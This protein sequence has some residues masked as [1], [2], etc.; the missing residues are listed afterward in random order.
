LE[1]RWRNLLVVVL[2]ICAVLALFYLYSTQKPAFVSDYVAFIS[3]ME[4]Y[5]ID[6]KYFPQTISGI[7]KLSDSQLEKLSSELKAFSNKTD[8]A[9]LKD[10]SLIYSDF[11]DMQ[12]NKKKLEKASMQARSLGAGVCDRIIMFKEM[13]ERGNKIVE[14]SSKLFRGTSDFISKYPEKSEEIKIYV[15]PSSV[16]LSKIKDNYKMQSSVVGALMEVCK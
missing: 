5:G 11:A 3:L 10:L 7:S 6:A 12:L 2:V 14:L 8:G 4:K 15:V 13:G 1:N 16:Q 9:W